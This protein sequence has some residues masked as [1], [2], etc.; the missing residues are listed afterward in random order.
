MSRAWAHLMNFQLGKRHDGSG[1][2][3]S[4]EAG[5]SRR[6]TV[7]PWQISMGIPSGEELS[8]GG[9]LF[10]ISHR[11]SSGSLLSRVGPGDLHLIVRNLATISG[12]LKGPLGIGLKIPTGKSVFEIGSLD[13]PTGDEAWGALATFAWSDHR[14]GKFIFHAEITYLLTFPFTASQVRGQTLLKNEIKV[15]YG[16]SLKGGVGVDLQLSDGLSVIGELT[17][18]IRYERIPTYALDG[19]DA[20]A[21]VAGLAFPEY[22]LVF[23]RRFDITPMVQI[24]LFSPLVISVGWQFPIDVVNGY[25]GESRSQLIAAAAFKYP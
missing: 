21:D 14:Y 6:W 25:S 23:A 22:P 10:D 15:G 3:A 4:L 2:A 24:K 11:L 13:L 18:F 16:H 12:D 19:S 17:G 1:N 20:G 7:L 5:E 8:L 9:T